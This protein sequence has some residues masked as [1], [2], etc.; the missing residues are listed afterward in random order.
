MKTV[1]ACYGNGKHITII[2]NNNEQT[3]INEFISNSLW[4]A[5]N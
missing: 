3:I 4:K 1:I 5:N 2:G